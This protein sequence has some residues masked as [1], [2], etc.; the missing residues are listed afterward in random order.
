MSAAAGQ[1]VVT[2]D[3]FIPAESDRYFSGIQQQAGRVNKL[4]HVRRPTPLDDQ[5]IVRMNKDTLYSMGIVDTAQ[6]A[7]ITMPPIHAGRYASIYLVDN[8]HYVPFVIYEP[9]THE[10]PR[11]TRY[12]GIGVRIQVFDADNADEIALVTDFRT[13]SRSTPGVPR[14][15]SHPHGIRTRSTRSGPSV[16]RSSRPTN[17]GPRTGRSVVA[18]STRRHGTSR[19][20]APGVCSRCRTPH[21]SATAATTTRGLCHTATYE[22]PEND[23]FWSITVYGADGY[24]KSNNNIVNSSNAVT[25][26]DGTFTVAFGPPQSCEDVPN[27]LD[28]SDGW[29]FLMRVYRP[30]PTVLDGTYKLP[31]AVPAQSN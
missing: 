1:R 8:D 14:H 21:T 17:G 31:R 15:S 26:D 22:T 28:V 7:T 18:R 3:T 9:G 13:S 11:D 23:A 10:L 25:N 12:L 6:G 20:R 24:I 5:T 4:F 29:N 16:R 19:P 27:R 30:G 2:P